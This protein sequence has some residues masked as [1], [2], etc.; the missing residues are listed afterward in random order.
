MHCLVFVRWRDLVLAVFF[1]GDLKGNICVFEKGMVFFFLWLSVY[2]DGELFFQ[3][4][5]VYS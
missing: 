4:F 5:S 2:W 3:R 1:V